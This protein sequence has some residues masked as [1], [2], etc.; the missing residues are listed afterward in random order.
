MLCFSRSATPSSSPASSPT[1]SAELHILRH[2][3]A[4]AATTTSPPPPTTLGG[5]NGN[6]FSKQRGEGSSI[7]TWGLLQGGGDLVHGAR[8]LPIQ[9]SFVNVVKRILVTKKHCATHGV[10]RQR[11]AQ[12]SPLCA[13]SGRS[14]Q[15]REGTVRQKTKIHKRRTAYSIQKHVSE[16]CKQ[17]SVL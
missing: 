1:T 12:L 14:V 15:R 2:L 13:W 17:M 10:R 7:R 5:G 16:Q 9:L 11:R 3:G 8:G 6:E 4:R